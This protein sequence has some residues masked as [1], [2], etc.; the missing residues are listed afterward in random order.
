ML[1][2]KVKDGHKYKNNK[3]IYFSIDDEKLMLE[4]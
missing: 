2:F 3:L 4:L 1:R